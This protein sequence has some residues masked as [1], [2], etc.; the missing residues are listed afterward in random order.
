MVGKGKLYE[1]GFACTGFSGL[2]LAANTFLIREK[3]LYIDE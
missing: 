1:G 3:Q 2:P